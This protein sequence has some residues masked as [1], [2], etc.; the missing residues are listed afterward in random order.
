[1]SMEVDMLRN[2]IFWVEVAAVAAGVL[3]LF[4][5]LVPNG[6]IARLGFMLGLHVAM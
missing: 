1:M 3:A 6:T 5:W 4:G 2:A